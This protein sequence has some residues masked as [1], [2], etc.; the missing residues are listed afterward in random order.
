MDPIKNKSF[1]QLFDKVWGGAEVAMA[2]FLTEDAAIRII[3]NRL[4]E[5]TANLGDNNISKLIKVAAALIVLRKRKE[6]APRKGDLSGPVIITV[7][8]TDI[9]FPMNILS[10]SND[11]RESFG[12][13][14][15]D[16]NG[17]ATGIQH[18]DQI[19]TILMA[20]D[21]TNVRDQFTN[22]TAQEYIGVVNALIAIHGPGPVQDFVQSL[23]PENLQVL[24]EGNGNSIIQIPNRV[25]ATFNLFSSPSA[26][27]LEVAL[28]PNEAPLE[29]RAKTIFDLLYYLSREND[30]YYNTI[31]LQDVLNG[32]NDS[33]LDRETKI[34]LAEVAAL[35]VRLVAREPDPNSP[36]PDNPNYNY[37]FQNTHT[38][39]VNGNDVLVGD[40]TGNAKKIEEVYRDAGVFAGKPREINVKALVIAGVASFAV[41]ALGLGIPIALTNGVIGREL[42][43]GIVNA[44]SAFIKEHVTAET[45]AKVE[46]LLQNV[47][48]QIG[49]GI[50]VA[51]AIAGTAIG[52]TYALTTTPKIANMSEEV[53]TNISNDVKAL[54]VIMEKGIGGELSN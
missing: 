13:L 14:E 2:G 45:H 35:T 53:I 4:D 43:F 47:G 32:I 36:D 44:F 28:H 51:L 40:L 54:A 19:L 7:P 33:E 3:T 48:V 6:T 16:V 29:A 38:V 18:Q 30:P 39:K 31:L 52:I 5:T 24:A 49:A 21:L 50:F 1:D 27:L 41:V 10:F 11:S 8:H 17:V 46:A 12:F 34:K 42:D 15:W 37:Q 25:G 22:L 23:V 9:R 20:D 26:L